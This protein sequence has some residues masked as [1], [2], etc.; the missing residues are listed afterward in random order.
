MFFTV[1]EFHTFVLSYV[2]QVL[3]P[4]AVYLRDGPS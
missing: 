3:L 2:F 1:V 4:Q